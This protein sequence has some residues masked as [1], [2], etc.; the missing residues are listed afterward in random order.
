MKVLLVLPH[1]PDYR[2]SFLR[3][4]GSHCDLTVIARPCDEGSLTPPPSR[5]GYKYLESGNILFLLKVRIQPLLFYHSVSKYDVICCPLNV[6]DISFLFLFLKSRVL[7]KLFIWR[8]HIFGSRSNF[9]LKAFRYFLLK[10]ASRVLT[11]D[12]QTSHFLSSRYQIQAK[13]FNNS[14]ISIDDYTPLSYACDIN[15]SINILFVGRYQKRKKIDRLF[16][17]LQEFHDIHLRLIGPG[18]EDL[19]IPKCIQDRVSIYPRLIG[20]ELIPHFEWCHVIV[21]PGHLGLL[22]VTAAMYCRTIVVDKYS[23]HAPEVYLAKQANQFFVD[24][25]DTNEVYFILNSL[26]SSNDLLASKACCLHETAKH[27]YN[28]EFMVDT[29]I[30][31]FHNSLANISI[32]D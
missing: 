8:G 32:H 1:A 24:F 12:L 17:L 21:N 3:L 6:N 30:D 18:F 11:Y 13:S 22:V 5:L 7:T 19:L 25:N 15:K 4:L 16:K 20:L 26:R 23:T 9:L 10:L 27:S 29:H 14:H 2:E 28:I 31:Y